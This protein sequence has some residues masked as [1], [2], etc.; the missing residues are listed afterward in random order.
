MAHQETVNLIVMLSVSALMAAESLAAWRRLRFAGGH[1]LSLALMVGAVESLCYAL[2]FALGEGQAMLHLAAIY[3]VTSPL[4]GTFWLI[5]AVRFAGL[6]L[7]HGRWLETILVGVSVGLV[8]AVAAD[9][10]LI[11]PS[12]AGLTALHVDRVGSTFFSIELIWFYVLMAAG[13]VLLLLEALRSWRL[14]RAQVLAL[15]GG[16]GSV[17]VLDIAFTAGFQPVR[18]LHLGLAVFAGGMLVLIWALPRL[19]SVDLLAAWQ[20]RILD[21][22][23]DAVLVV[24]GQGRIVNANRAAQRLLAAETQGGSAA[25]TLADRPWLAELVDGEAG[26]LDTLKPESIWETP[27]RTVTV[28][29]DGEIRHFDLRRSALCDRRGCEL[30]RVLVLRDVTER[31]E[32]A[33]ALDEAND[34]L[35]TLV[36]AGLEFGASLRIEDVLGAVARRMREL[37]EADECDLYRFEDG[38]ML[39][40]LMAEDGVV[41]GDRADLT[42]EVADYPLTEEALRTRQP[43]CVYD[44]AEDPRLSEAERSDAARFGYRSSVDLPLIAGG[45]VVGLAVLTDARPRAFEH[46]EV[47]QGLAHNAAQA[48]VN[49]RMYAQL[50]EKAEHLALVSEAGSLFSSTLSVDEVLLSTCKRL[51]EMADAPICSVYVVDDGSLRCRASV[52]DGEVDRVWMAQS[53]DLEQWLSTRTTL[54][55]HAPVMIESL[56]DPRLSDEQ[57]ASM[58]ERGEVSLLAVPLVA[59]GEAFGTVE[60][61]DRR[62]RTVTEDE[63]RAMEAVC[64]AAALAIRSA[65]MFGREHENATRL[66][67]LLDA[68][69]ATTSTVVLDRVLPI[70]AEKTCTAVGSEECIIWEY[71]KDEGVLAE[72]TYYSSRQRSY[73][74]TD[75][76]NLNDDPVR[77]AIL[78]G[79]VIVEE[80]I[81][82][83]GL[84]P[85]SRALVEERD[86][87]SRL[88]VPLVF[89]GEPIGMLVLVETERERHFKPDEL[90]LVRALAEQ[91]AVAIQN[92]RQYER[93]E[94]ATTLLASQVEL[95]Q[96]LLELSGTL[97][98]TLDHEE[99]FSRIATLVK[100]VVDYDCM[101]IR[102]V[103]SEARELFCAYARAA[104]AEY[105]EGWRSSLDEGVSGWVVRHNEAQ[106]VNDMLSD[107]RSAVVAGTEDEPQAS[108]IVPLTVGG[109]VIGVL[110]LDRTEGLTFADHELEAAKLFANLAAIAIQ[111]SRQY[112][113][114]RRMHA[115]NLRTLCTALNAKD[116]YTLGH[117][118]RV[119]AY[120]RLLG[121]E[122]GWSGEAVHRIGEAAYLHDIGKIGIPDRILTKVGKL[123]QREWELMRQHP[124]LSADIIGPLYADDVVLGV[125]HHHERYDGRGY[126]DGLAGEEIPLIARAMCVV[127]SYDAMSFDRPYH[128]GL[129]LTDCLAELEHCKGSQF[130]P[131]MVDA[132]ARVLAGIASVR[133]RGLAIGAQ[134]AALIDVDAHVALVESGSEDDPAY[135]ETVRILCAVRDA[136]PGVRYVTTVARRGAG[137]II[138]CD[139]EEDEQERSP[140]GEAVASDVELPRVLAGET[141]DISLVSADQYG[142]WIS[143]TTPLTR[144]DGEI[145]GAVSVDFPAYET[146]EEDGL[147]G[148]AT[149][150]LTRLLVGASE[151]V[152]RAEADAATDLLSG[153]Y[154]HGRLHEGLAEQISR[155]EEAGG[156]LSLVLCDVD[157]LADFNRLVGHPHG[158]EALR[159]IGQLIESASR[160]TDLCA[161]FGGDEFALV[162]NDGGTRALEVAETLREAVESAKIDA[163]GRSLTMSVGVATYPLDGQNND[164]LID[165]ARWAVDLAK[166]RGRNR[167]VRFENHGNGSFSSG[168]KQALRYLAMMAKLADAGVR[169]EE[170]HSDAVARLAAALAAELGLS[171]Q[172]VADVR[173]AARLRDI[174]QFGIPDHVLSKPS[175][176]SEEE[177]VLIREHP[178][179]GE[180]LLRH[181]GFDSVADAV[182]HHHER[183][184]GTGYPLA[185]SGEQIPLGAQ[186]V[187]VASS[188]QALVNRRPYRPERSADEALEE[189]RRCAGSQFDPEMVAALERVL[190]HG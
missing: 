10:S 106:L 67:F 71:R 74:P 90:E 138:V 87:K 114:V 34:D 92:A 125:R 176:L 26:G 39:A 55:T 152:S 63:M 147:R 73:A 7:P 13:V 88:S 54:E 163:G 16:I 115:N 132:F 94:R 64:N 27:G 21:E 159:L 3:A 189:M 135:S 31:V 111:N 38:R 117:T 66:A 154:T 179:A 6:R 119:A 157:R 35:R 52:Y 75:S 97:L 186:I 188:F 28:G 40:L 153:L 161:R 60:V 142:V 129:G 169:Y 8:V 184:D 101:E 123:N 80:S 108:I 178:R 185:L 148:D 29:V 30:S 4:T 15:I 61:V 11:F 93:L 158:D 72:R 149:Q 160:P 91:A 85:L 47:L 136:S 150:T 180:R 171:R 81:S 167:C 43:M 37:V 127:D 59:R 177:W 45:R 69:R 76:V 68:S 183:F 173:E 146:A 65:D 96:V 48:L 49:S 116:F 120:M 174:G 131:V 17:F 151:R 42:F 82:D 181:M 41:I 14:Y 109:D 145:V 165:R 25:T 33:R 175:A 99:V 130:D 36:D 62:P 58:R 155:A 164:A 77:R 53:F 84:H 100:R 51:C 104:D 79:G 102:L 113:D 46:L 5:F 140:L 141:P 103:D 86:E 122:L 187:A 18:G 56:D 9:P 166:R 139:A 182:A 20:P 134:A 121:K 50:G 137:Q 70:V 124:T 98:G 128:R 23:S 156:E 89:D 83:E 118:A 24:D 1:A 190:S 32:T 78:E 133:L 143:A 95:R 112:E 105:L 144:P 110:V 170:K 2:V 57:R 19:R 172:E 107:P 126:P 12:G 162:L 22:M 168:R 44:A